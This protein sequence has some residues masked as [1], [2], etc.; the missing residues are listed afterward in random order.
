MIYKI[1]NNFT[2]KKLRVSER[3]TRVFKIFLKILQ[4]FSNAFFCGNYFLL[5]NFFLARN[6]FLEFLFLITYSH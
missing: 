6:C 2:K 1:L 4:E 5:W 3:F